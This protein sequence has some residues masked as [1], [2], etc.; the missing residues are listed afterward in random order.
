MYQLNVCQFFLSIKYSKFIYI[1]IEFL[2]FIGNDV[3]VTRNTTIS[4]FNTFSMKIIKV[5]HTLTTKSFL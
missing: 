5:T 3:E 4:L 1:L 2:L